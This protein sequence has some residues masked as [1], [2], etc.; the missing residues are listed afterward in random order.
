MRLIDL[1]ET[2]KNACTSHNYVK[3][4]NYGNDFDFGA[5]NDD[6]Y[7][8]CYYELPLIIDSELNTNSPYTEVRFGFYVFVDLNN[9]DI[10]ND[11]EAN[12]LALEIGTEIFEYINETS[13]VVNIVNYNGVTLREFGDDSA[14]GIRFDVTANIFRKCITDFYMFKTVVNE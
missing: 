14:A 13:N 9:D 6:T 2:I 5:S 11:Y 12:A 8:M 10:V 4:F 1:K 7:P 3:S